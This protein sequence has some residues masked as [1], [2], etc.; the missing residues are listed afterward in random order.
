MPSAHDQIM[1]YDLCLSIARRRNDYF[2]ALIDLDEFIR[3]PQARAGYLREAINELLANQTN[4]PDQVYLERFDVDTDSKGFALERTNRFVRPRT[5]MEYGKR[6]TTERPH[7]QSVG[8]STC[9]CL[10][11]CP[12]S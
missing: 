6:K 8:E 10:W 1:A 7:D 9:T 4:L 2:T 5:R 12:Y 11:W 3:Y